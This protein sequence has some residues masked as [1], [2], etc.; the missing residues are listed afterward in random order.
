MTYEHDSKNEPFATGLRRALAVPSEELAGFIESMMPSDTAADPAQLGIARDVLG[1]L[2]EAVRTGEPE[3]WS[4]LSDV[5]RILYPPMDDASSTHP[6]Q[7][8]AGSPGPS[9]WAARGAPSASAASEPSPWAASPSSAPAELPA[10]PRAAASS[11]LEPIARLAETAPTS[12]LPSGPAMPFRPGLPGEPSP[13][14]KPSQRRDPLEPVAG[15]GE[16]R[17]AK[18]DAELRPALPFGATAEVPTLDVE[19][20]ALLCAQLK[21]HPAQRAQVLAAWKLDEEGFASLAREYERRFSEDPELH[22]RWA[23]MLAR[24]AYS[25]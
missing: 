19:R 5:H 16:T 2:C 10:P 6:P 25:T 13:L 9:P 12:T 18:P 4:K 14:A 15:F 23:G 3:L 17:A 24:Q 11:A 20:Y 22:G 8:A 21:T 1:K 7:P